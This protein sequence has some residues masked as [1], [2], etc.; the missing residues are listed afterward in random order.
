MGKLWATSLLFRLMLIV[1]CIIGLFGLVTESVQFWS[2]YVDKQT[3]LRNE[4]VL[5]VGALVN[6]QNN[7]YFQAQHRLKTFLEVWRALPEGITLNLN[8][9]DVMFIPFADN[10]MHAENPQLYK[11]MQAVKLFGNAG[12]SEAIYLI[13]PQQGMIV[14]HPD[15][16]D[17]H[18]LQQRAAELL[19]LSKQ[20]PDSGFH[21][22]APFR[23]ANRL[24]VPVTL[25]LPD[26]DAI[27]GI[28][29]DVWHMPELNPELNEGIAFAMLDAA[30]H[31]LPLSSQEKAIPADEFPFE[32]LSRCQS[33]HTVLYQG[34]N[35]VCKPLKGPGWQLIARYPQ[36]KMVI[37]AL[38]SQLWTLPPV[39]A[40]WLT[41][42]AIIY[43]VLLHQVIRPLRR[44]V[45]VVDRF[46]FMDWAHSLTEGRN[47]ELGRIAR[48]Y[49]RLL[50]V[51]RA[52]YETLEKRVHE[53]TRAL[54][55]A[56]RSAEQLSSS[57]SI[58]MASISHEIR[59]PMNGVVGALNLLQRS[60]L[61]S[62]QQELVE[63]AHTS[64]DYLL[65]IINNLLDYNHIEAGQLQMSYASTE[66]LPLLDRVLTTVC[67]S[68]NAKGLKL[69]SLVV[70]NLPE[71]IEISQIRVKQILINMLANA[72]KF[73]EQ[74][75]VRLQ[76]RRQ[77][78]LLMISVE[79]SGKGISPEHLQTIF[80]PFVQV[81]EHSGG[82]GLGLTISAMLAQLMGGEIKVTS[83]PGKG[84][85]F[86]LLLPINHPGKNL[87]SFS[88]TLLAPAVLHQQL[89]LWGITPQEGEHPLLASP[90][91]V[92]LPGRL[93][94]QLATI[95]GKVYKEESSAVP[96]LSPWSLKVLVVD[97]IAT[98]R[99]IV[100][101]IL[102]G[103][104]H[105]PDSV[106][107]GAQAL[108]AG[109]LNVYDMVLMDLRMP[110]MDGFETAERWRAPLSGILDEDTPIIALTA[111]TLSVDRERVKQSVMNGYLAKPLRMEKLM[112]VIDHVVMVQLARGTEL[113]PNELLQRPLLDAE[114]DA[115]MQNKLRATLH[116]FAQRIEESWQQQQ[117][118]T[119]LALLHALKGCA[120]L[121]GIDDIFHASEQ[122]ET[123]VR[124]GKW[125]AE[126]QMQALLSRLVVASGRSEPPA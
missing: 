73:T 37:R 72:I 87:E 9:H 67:V 96:T 41:L 101:K 119:L 70:A 48:A 92:Y 121:A 25:Q 6:E 111:N 58:H 113:M 64:A 14:Y 55:D 68:A 27:S 118:H 33:N 109:R 91:L 52:H 19:A 95:Y 76:V 12:E 89:Q 51:I 35:Y 40:V 31:L 18:V 94:R 65:S 71:S 60:R 75:E 17:K 15:S 53:R 123:E 45:D 98:N 66:L 10:Q 56:R 116:S 104:G 110:D 78:N 7:H 97:D 24:Y 13:L 74:G 61:T 108:D 3:T 2:R 100:S 77:G 29:L 115:E 59:T 99:D 30:N 79:D 38:E 103:L 84:S 8:A 90:A 81:S 1:S 105:Q 39:A 80:R 21:W 20:H 125:P 50:V 102:R 124:H 93:H 122:L 42:L 120:G 126:Q 47:D 112:Q 32:M 28:N 43:W 106:A 85:C 44:F 23:T 11:A 86:T 16:A 49:N 117:Q 114:Q 4:L 5:E 36:Q 22:G 69:S 83:Q 82:N 26:S 107:S 57:K 46:R 62:E 63:T 88:G 54:D 34:F